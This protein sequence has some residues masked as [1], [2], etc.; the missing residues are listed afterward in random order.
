[1]VKKRIVKDFAGVRLTA[2]LGSAKSHAPVARHISIIS[3][4]ECTR[5]ISEHQTHMYLPPQAFVAERALYLTV[6]ITHQSSWLG[7]SLYPKGRRESTYAFDVQRYVTKSAQRVSP[8]D[9]QV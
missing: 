1:M 5:S 8:R 7:P 2:P 4:K 3:T 6:T 9:C